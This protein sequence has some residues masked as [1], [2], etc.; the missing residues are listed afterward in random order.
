MSLSFA[1]PAFL[2]LLA[3]LPLVVLLHFLRSRTRRVEVSALFLWERAR[4]VA[5]RRRRFSPTW[6]LLLQLLAVAFAALALSQPDL[7]LEGPPDLVVV[8][9]AS[10]SM[11]AIDPEGARLTRAREA[12]ERLASEAGRVALVRAGNEPRLVL[13][14]SDDGAALTAALEA[15]TPADRDVD[16]ERALALA[17]DLARASGEH[18][19]RVALVSDEPGPPRAGVLRVD[20]G[21]SGVNVGIVGFDLGIQQAF[22]AVASNAR[23][24]RS[25]AIELWHEGVRLAATELLIPAGDQASATFPLDVSAGVV[26]AR[27]VGLP[28]DDALAL[29]DVAYAGQRPL[30]V[31]IDSDIESVRRALAAVPGVA[32]RLTGLA[33]SAPGDVRVLTGVALDDLPAGDVIL[34]PDPTA[35]PD[36][37]TVRTWDRADPLLRFVDLREV[38]VGLP[39]E[40]A[41]LPSGDEPDWTVLA[42]SAD[43]TP[44]LRW[45]DDE[46]GRVLQF[47]F[48]PNQTD[49]IFRPA[50]PTLFA[51][52]IERFRGEA[53]VP[54]GATGDAGEPITTP[55]PVV[56]AGRSATAS[57]LS[58]QQTRLPGAGEDDVDVAEPLLSVERPTPLAAWLLALAL[59]ALAA[60][61]WLWSRG[62]GA[63]PRRPRRAPGRPRPT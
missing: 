9:D 6:S 52:A 19:A 54:L 33:R 59:L 49:M 7:R 27:L 62:P 1:A 38:V 3:A 43:L 5:E 2:W 42:R 14:F 11:A 28:A 22:V 63:M 45:R 31:L 61:W 8:L 53:R 48:H 20:V 12:V 29:D 50:F 40:R 25:A 23:G 16:L 26:E 15:F 21:G 60:E 18:E 10:A 35:A 44:L 36:F 39:A 55:G 34:F 24:P 13:P 46:R 17:H 58:L 41:S 51:N 47:L 32:T 30:D 4:Q 37:V 57:L 56:I